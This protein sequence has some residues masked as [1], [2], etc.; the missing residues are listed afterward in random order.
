MNWLHYLEEVNLYLSVFYLCYCLFLNKETYYTLNRVYLL[1]SCLISLALPLTQIGLLKPTEV[2][3]V[4]TGPIPFDPGMSPLQY[5]LLY[6]YL[7]GVCVLIVL[8]AAKLYKLIEISRTGYI[9]DDGYKLIY[10][11]GSNTAFSFF[12]CLF[13]GTDAPEAELIRQHE[14]VHI[15]QKHSIDII[16]LE[17][18]KIVNW[19]NPLV[20]LLQN[21]LKTVHEYIADEKT[22]AHE[23]DRLTYSTFLV[24]NAYGLSGSSITHSF[25]NYNLLKKRIIMLHQ[26]RSS[27]LAALKYFITVPLCAALL[28]ESTLGFS[29]TYGWINIGPK[30]AVIQ[31][32]VKKQVPPPPPP[33]P[34]KTMVKVTNHKLPPPPVPSRPHVDQVKFPPPIVRTDRKSKHHVVDQVKFPPPIVRTDGKPGAQRSHKT[35]IK[36]VVLVPPADKR[37]PPPPP[38]A[39]GN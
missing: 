11:E 37:Q 25:F 39:P 36:Q 28:C 2:P 17:L 38:V 3:V 8:F 24:N 23:T 32:P 33:T 15:R 18:F 1:F 20:Y 26:E 30:K 21:S 35:K 29:K 10:I 7:I 9:G 22:A 4:I 12:N 16:F 31:Q 5:T 13:I 14:L 19:F 27:G 34:P 6:S